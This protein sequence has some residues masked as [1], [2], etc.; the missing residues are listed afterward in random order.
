MTPAD[1]E[2]HRYLYEGV[3]ISA[4]LLLGCVTNVAVVWIDHG[5]D[6]ATFDPA[7]PWVLEVSS[8]LGLAAM[9]PL[10]LWFDRVVPISRENW[11]RAVPA[12]IA[13]SVVFS[14]GHVVL[15]YLIRQWA[16][17]VFVGH[18]YHWVNWAAQFFYE[19]LKDFRTYFYFLAFVYLYRLVLRR[20]RGEAGFVEESGAVADAGPDGGDRGRVADR[21][22]VKKLGREFLIRAESI[23]WIESSG[24]YVNLHVAGKVYPMRATMQQT[25]ERL[26]SIGFARVHRS[27]IVNLDQVANILVHSTGDGELAL[28]TGAR[29]PVSRRYR[30]ALREQ[31]DASASPA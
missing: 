3:L 7:L 19:Y 8:H 28:H 12:H 17:P 25:A 26:T 15:M 4:L 30:Q 22:L 11:R 5:R 6:G 14:L 10:L 23:E 2:R 29:V 18:G 16:F 31:L 20:W 21:F 9:V 1:F 27:A 13:F 24:N